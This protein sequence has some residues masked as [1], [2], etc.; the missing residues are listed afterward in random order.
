MKTGL[1][2]YSKGEPSVSDTQVKYNLLFK[3]IPQMNIKDINQ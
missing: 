1:D 2:S 3:D